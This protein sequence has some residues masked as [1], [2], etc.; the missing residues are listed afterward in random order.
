M[1]DK[2]GAVPLLEMLI[3]III[4]LILSY[5]AFGT[6]FKMPFVRTPW[7]TYAPTGSLQK[8]TSSATVLDAAKANV[9]RLNQRM[10]E[11]D[12]QLDQITR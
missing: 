10:R 11:R 8:S 9:E 6:Y 4:I 12:Q 1:E 3:V 2:K 7:G 5:F